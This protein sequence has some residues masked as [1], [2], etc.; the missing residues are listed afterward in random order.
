MQKQIW[1]ISAHINSCLQRKTDIEAY[2]N[3]V[4]IT[5]RNQ[6]MK[7]FSKV[8]TNDVGYDIYAYCYVTQNLE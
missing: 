4:H 8:C 6:N 5:V 2:V 3:K 7:H 1:N